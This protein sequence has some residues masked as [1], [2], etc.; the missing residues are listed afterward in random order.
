[1]LITIKLI[2]KRSLFYLCVSVSIGHRF[3]ITLFLRVW[4]V[5]RGSISGDTGDDIYDRTITNKISNGN[6]RSVRNIAIRNL[7]PD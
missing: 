3:C 5:A 7:H 6:A 1:M 2:T 4:C